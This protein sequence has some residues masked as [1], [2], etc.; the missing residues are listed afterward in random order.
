MKTYLGDSVYAEHDGYHVV[1][2]TENG[3][4]SDPSNIIAL[5]P[6][7]ISALNDFVRKIPGISRLEPTEIARPEN[8]S[9]AAKLDLGFEYAQAHR[10]RIIRGS[11]HIASI[12][13]KISDTVDFNPYG[14]T[15]WFT[16]S[17]RDDVQELLRLAPQWKK[18]I[19][20]TGIDYDATVGGVAYKIRTTDGALPPTCRLVEKDVEIPAQPAM[21]ARMV[22][23]LVV[24]CEQ[25][26]EA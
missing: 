23:R 21:P 22:K 16:V 20:E 2:T 7:V 15:F 26:V 13:P 6:E 18:N 8:G 12:N 24:E 4:E 3:L 1:L 19:H 10:T 9:L 11:E 25:P 14:G 5:E 17:N